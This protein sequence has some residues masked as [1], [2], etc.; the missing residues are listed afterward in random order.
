ML[1]TS[2]ARDIFFQL[3]S[4]GILPSA[5][6]L[7][8]LSDPEFAMSDELFDITEHL[9]AILA[10]CRRNVRLSGKVHAW[11]AATMTDLCMKEDARLLHPGTR[12]IHLTLPLSR[13]GSLSLAAMASRITKVRSD[14]PAR[15]R[16]P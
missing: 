5:L 10:A 6:F 1:P 4:S 13:T 2:Y 7:S 16:N 11:A 8:L 12:D 14:P 9:D 3:H 15:L